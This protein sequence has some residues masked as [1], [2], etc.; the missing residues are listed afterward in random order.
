LPAIWTGARAQVLNIDRSIS[1]ALDLAFLRSRALDR[2]CAQGV[3][4]RLG[5][6]PAEGLAAALLDG[7][8]DDLTNADLRYAS[9][10]DKT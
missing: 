4:G 2:T 9:L 1:R 3:P 10:A 8:M 5:I 6:E 7:A